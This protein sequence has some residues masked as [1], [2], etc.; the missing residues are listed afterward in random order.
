V[1]TL[2]DRV[3]PD[4]L[5]V[6]DR[7]GFDAVVSRAVAIES[8]PPS[9]T[10]VRAT[11]FGALA[12]IPAGGYFAPDSKKR[13]VV[14]L[15]DGESVATDTD[16]L[17]RAFATPP[18]YT[19]LTV[20]FWRGGESIYRGAEPEAAYRPDPT[21]AASLAALADATDGRA[22]EETELAA[23]AGFLRSAVGDGPTVTTAG[24][25][26]TRTLFAP[27]LVALALLLLAGLAL[28]PGL[29]RLGSRRHEEA[30]IGL[31]IR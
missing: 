18:G 4:L 3:L 1:A 21:G 29:S 31:A 24:T 19:L 27:Y 7:A 23:G 14:L 2:T 9:A 26:R 12:A 25:T 10:S 28:R 30:D 17:A 16:A 20:R 5:P 8:P 15:T 22:F 13:I 6:A 11:S